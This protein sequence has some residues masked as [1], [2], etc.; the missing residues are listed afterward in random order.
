MEP[1]AILP[2]LYGLRR[3][4][5]QGLR[6]PAGALGSA[7]LIALVAALPVTAA[8]AIEATAGLKVGPQVRVSEVIDGDTVAIATPVDGASQVRLVGIQAPKLALGRDGFRP[9]P[10]APE[11]KA[12]VEVMALG[13]SF[14]LGF[15]GARHDRHGR[16]L[17]H[18]IADDGTWVQGEMLRR[19][20]A[21]VYTFADNRAR[22]ADM[23]A[24]EREA[25]ARR[26][27]I[28]RLSYYALQ[29]PETAARHV[30][31]FQ[32]VEGRVV[33]VTAVRGRIYI[34]FGADWRTDFTVMLAPAAARLFVDGAAGVL[35]L[36]DR[37]VRVRGWLRWQDGPMIE[38]THP[39]QIESP[40]D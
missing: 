6:A 12:A 40:L 19:G 34:N 16:L 35:A 23:L 1:T 25:R 15:G 38:A 30:G 32:I 27:G 37:N 13:Q 26:L 7:G 28:W 36:K 20:L 5:R 21:R 33:N 18:L 8:P 11:A 9:W 39:E 10:L 4:S 14:V 29:T 24:F 31:T 22:A 3:R 17:A 2:A